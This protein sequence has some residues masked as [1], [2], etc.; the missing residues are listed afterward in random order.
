MTLLYFILGSVFM[1]VGI[2]ILDA[3]ADLIHNLSQLIMYKTAFKIY[4]YKKQMGIDKEEQEEEDKKLPMGFHTD[5]I[6]I[7][8]ENSS[9]EEED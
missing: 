2:P 7:Q 8:I 3:F 4:S 5:V 1:I 9:N 6:G